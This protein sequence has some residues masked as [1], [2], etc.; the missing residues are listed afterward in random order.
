MGTQAIGRELGV[1]YVLE[2]C[3][4]RAGDQVRISVRLVDTETAEQ[5]W[6]ERGYEVAYAQFEVPVNKKPAPPLAAIPPLA[7]SEARDHVTIEGD[8][9]RIVFSRHTGAIAAWDYRALLKSRPEMAW[10]LTVHMP[11]R[12]REAQKREDMLRA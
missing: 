4:R 8:E 3:L 9:F 5:L 6:A 12:L 10:R 2:G 11:G 1:R 7:V